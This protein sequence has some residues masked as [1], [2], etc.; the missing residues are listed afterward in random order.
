[1]PLC[2]LVLTLWLRPLQLH[3]I[4]TLCLSPALDLSS[5]QRLPPALGDVPTAH[6]WR[7]CILPS[8]VCLLV[9]SLLKLFLPEHAAFGGMWRCDEG[10]ELIGAN[11][12]TARAVI[13]RC[14]Y[15]HN[16]S[17]SLGREQVALGNRPS[18][19]SERKLWKR[20]SEWVFVF[21]SSLR[22]DFPSLTKIYN[23]T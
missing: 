3:C 23:F 9:S 2:K 14:I 10:P 18:P 11:I 19:L 20:Q 12:P 5:G 1:M 22:V 8:S 16:T 15:S 17:R 7:G 6:L 21:H 13:N 4:Q